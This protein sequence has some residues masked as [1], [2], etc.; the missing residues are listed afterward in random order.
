MK[1]KQRVKTLGA[2]IFFAGAACF[3]FYQL[4]KAV[5]LGVIAGGLLSA[6]TAVS[7]HDQPFWFASGV[8]CWSVIGLG[9]ITILV[10]SWYIARWEDRRL[11]RKLST[12][13]VDE[14]RISKNER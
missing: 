8:I 11:L 1:I 3:S 12:P 10:S 7:V 6:G 9:S 13:F 14:T 2:A 4:Y 5:F